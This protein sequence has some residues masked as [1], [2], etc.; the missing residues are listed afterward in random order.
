MCDF[1]KFSVDFIRRLINESEEDVIKELIK[2]C[3]KLDAPTDRLCRTVVEVVGRDIIKYIRE[4]GGTP[5]EV[6]QRFN[7]CSRQKEEKVVAKKVELPEAPQQI[8]QLCIYGI[9]T[10]V[11]FLNESEDYIIEEANKQCNM[12]GDETVKRICL[13]MVSLFGRQVIRYVK[14]FGAENPREVCKRFALCGDKLVKLP[15][16]SKP[17]AL[18]TACVVAVSQVQRMINESEEEII[19]QLLDTCTLLPSDLQ[20][21]CRLVV[22]LY[23]KDLINYI[24][25][26]IGEPL[27]LCK[28]I[29]ICPAENK[30]LVN[31]AQKCYYSCLVNHKYSHRAT[32]KIFKICETNKLCYSKNIES[33]TMKCINRC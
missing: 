18:C 9:Q 4:I 32:E 30:T 23:A 15:R 2:E 20:Q 31:Q 29:G 5:I 21:Y 28:K 1:C 10:I 8:C 27:A 25:Q 33:E 11:N 26:S 19:R 12:I 13:T 14:E 22:N 3:N 17:E 16:P 24:K 7:L 6:C